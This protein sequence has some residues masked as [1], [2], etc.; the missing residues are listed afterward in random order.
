LKRIRIPI[1]IKLNTINTLILI[2]SF[3]AILYFASDVFKKDN[4]NYVNHL[5]I[6]IATANA[7]KV[8]WALTS[9]INNFIG[10]AKILSHKKKSSLILNHY[11]DDS[12]F[13]SISVFRKKSGK[14]VLK[15]FK[16]GRKSIKA[17][18]IN[19]KSHKKAI[20]KLLPE[21]NPTYNGEIKIIT[22]SVTETLPVLYIGIPFVQDEN[23]NFISIIV[24]AI[25][26]SKIL[27]MF[28][29]QSLFTTYLLDDNGTVLAH[30]DSQKVI[31]RI[32]YSAIPIVRAM[33]KG[34][35]S[36]GQQEYYDDSGRAQLGAYSLVG[37]SGIGVISQ[38]SRE[39]A[40]EATDILIK[41]S[42]ILSLIVLIFSII[43]IYLFSHTI[44]DPLNI[45]VEQTKKITAGIYDIKIKKKPSD[46]I[47]DL[48]SAFEEMATGLEQRERLKNTFGKFVNRDLA[49]QALKGELSLGGERKKVTVF[50]SDIRNFTAMSE[51]M[52]PEDVLSMLN[53]YMSKMVDVITSRGG[54]VD[55]FVGDAIMAIWGAPINR[56]DDAL[57]AV[58]ACLQMRNALYD[59]NVKRKA[60]SLPELRIGMGLNT[61]TAIVGNMGSSEKMEYTAIGDTVNLASRIESQTKELKADILIN[62]TVYDEVKHNIEAI[63]C[64]RVTVKGKEDEVQL[65]R[66][67]GI[68]D[69]FGVLQDF[70]GD[71]NLRE[72]PEKD[73]P[74]KTQNVSAD[75]KKEWYANLDGPQTGP[76][77]EF[78][79]K[80]LLSENES[81]YRN[82]KIFK[83]GEK[84][85][86]PPWHYKKFDRRLQLKEK[87]S[88]SETGSERK[89][90]IW[91]IA[92]NRQRYGPFSIEEIKNLLHK[93]T[94]SFK[95]AIWKNG[96]PEW[97][98][99]H[100]LSEFD[101]RNLND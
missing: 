21:L 94:I 70:S 81:I 85:W 93:G 39:K 17:F 29:G 51:K 95:D 1:G 96:W 33:L 80:K 27:G 9:V 41:R 16:S 15:Y 11:L 12:S 69:N 97:K 54:V 83:E 91:F 78:E 72:H 25:N 48:G 65:Y 35:V 64:K 32:N 13:L 71:P 56:E 38:V 23:G 2:I 77:T 59:L 26:Q 28:E 73:I 18:G 66:V 89:E 79:I 19:L 36:S 92:Q 58:T 49:E 37:I 75:Q 98:P 34:D 45:L 90:K 30:P 10:A 101:R 67:I 88:I 24:G 76:Y 40:F 46:E 63:P 43:L 55:K 3:C 57:N 53:E 99:L 62:Q 84:T 8:K 87:T 86:M 14:N 52:Q 31:N 60:K 22:G 7:Q 4:R 6:K 61:G 20:K 47:G 5:N 42:A 50:F 82:I 68:K 74:R 44:T 100:S